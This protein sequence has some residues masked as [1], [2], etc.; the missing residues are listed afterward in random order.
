MAANCVFVPVSGTLNAL[1]LTLFC[2]Y[3]LL[4]YNFRCGLNFLWVQFELTLEYFLCLGY[5]AMTKARNRVIAPVAGALNVIALVCFWNVSI[6][7]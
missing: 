6:V 3:L 2:K 5:L 7:Y 1:A 4:A